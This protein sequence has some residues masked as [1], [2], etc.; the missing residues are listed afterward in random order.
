[1]T[2]QTTTNNRN[3]LRWMWGIF[4]FFW[5][6]FLGLLGLIGAGVFGELPTFEELENPKNALATEIYATDGALLGKYYIQNRSYTRF[7]ELSPFLIQALIATEDI[8]FRN[9]AGIDF[10]GTVAIGFYTLFGKKRG[11]S[12]ISQQL[13]KNLYPRTHRPNVFKL[14]I[15]KLREWITAVKIEKR[16]TKDEIIAL[17]FNTV[18]FGNN[19]YGIKSAARTYFNKST[20]ELTL[21]EAALLVGIL[22][23]TTVYSP[24]RNPEKA[25][26]R[27]NTVI[28]QM[29]KYN[30]LSEAEAEKF[31]AQP[32]QLDLH[33]QT[34][35]AGLATYFREYLRQYMLE[36]CENNPKPDGS[37]Y[38]IYKD[39]LRIYTTID[40]RLQ[41]HA[42]KS[43]VE[44]MTA[45]QASFDQHWKGKAPWGKDESL[46]IRGMKQTDRYMDMKEQGMSESEI[47]EVFK[48]PV[49]MR[50]FDWKTPGYFRDTVLSPMDSLRYAKRLLHT[51]FMAMDAK[52]GFVKAWVGGINID[53]SQYDHVNITAKR[54]VGST[55]KPIVYA[56][57]I[58]NGFNPCTPIPNQPV[59]FEDFNNWTPKNYDGVNGGSMTM[60]EGLAK[61]INNIV[62]FLMKQVGPESVMELSRRMGIQSAMEP[63]P[64]LCLGTFDIS[65]FEMVGAYSAFVNKGLAAKPV[66]I[67]RIEDK[68]GN[69]VAQFNSETSEAFSEETAYVMSQ[70]LK[71]SVKI[72]T[73]GRIRYRYGLHNEI[74]GK[75]GTTQN[76]SDG[77]FMGITPEMVLGCWTGADD[78]AVHFR[79]THL[80]GGANSALPLVGLFLQKA[81]A[82]KRVDWKPGKFEPPASLSTDISCAPYAVLPPDSIPVE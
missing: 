15:Y 57:A 29:A 68:S 16:Y 5:L 82:D 17:Y 30:V 72:G 25:L 7:E 3:Y 14:G 79:T 40:S 54:Q 64:S 66:F 46:L 12:T 32:L 48:Q 71:G 76:N 34:H 44:H 36:W 49:P 21:P 62:A 58:D 22:K 56:Q 75:T 42:E 73:A 81:Y 31:K 41:E 20:K 24:V 53:H 10:Q 78:R 9:H 37:K 69:V 39:G 60:F 1:M 6:C 35:D 8:R 70:L 26:A 65:L 38:N 27:R 80:G 61:S 43:M 45:L 47:K 63:Y 51:G 55:F 18:E 4:A 11:S 52:N 28:D 74:G 23:G 19:A 77:W 59:T 33:P 50:L 2:N 13:A 67:S